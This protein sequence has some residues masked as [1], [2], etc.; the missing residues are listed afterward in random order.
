MSDVLEQIFGEVIRDVEIF[1]ELFRILFIKDGTVENVQRTIVSFATI[2]GIL[3]LVAVK[4]KLSH[5][6]SHGVPVVIRTDFESILREPFLQFINRPLS[7]VVL[8]SFFAIQSFHKARPM[9]HG[10]RDY[11]RRSRQRKSSVEFLR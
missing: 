1:L 8:L 10:V 11:T 6:Q 9:V 4:L 7:R 3:F 5:C 2:V